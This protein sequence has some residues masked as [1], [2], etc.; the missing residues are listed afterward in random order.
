MLLG[1]QLEGRRSQ[2]EASHH[3]LGTRL[4]LRSQRGVWRDW[5]GG[6]GVEKPPSNAED[7]GSTRDLS[8]TRPGAA[9]PA[10]HSEGSR[11]QLCPEMA[12]KINTC[13]EKRSKVKSTPA[14]R[15]KEEGWGP[16]G[17]P[18]TCH[19]PGGE[20]DRGTLLQRAGR[21]PRGGVGRGRV[22]RARGRLCSSLSSLSRGAPVQKGPAGD[23]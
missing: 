3:P 19:P 17:S 11:C 21:E 14:P 15:P 12:K 1:S 18:G 7:S 5:R 2:V 23:R 22:E 16:A 4:H 10:C 9:E 8:P 6:P 20:E 13:F